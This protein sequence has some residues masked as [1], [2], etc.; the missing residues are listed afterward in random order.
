[1]R[2]P[3]KAAGKEISE[4]ANAA[5][6]NVSHRR[7]SPNSASYRPCRAIVLRLSAHPWFNTCD[8]VAGLT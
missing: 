5:S 6:T 3:R 2:D 4:Q 8:F 7:R 1:M